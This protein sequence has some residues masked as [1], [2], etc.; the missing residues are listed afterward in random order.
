MTTVVTD[1]GRTRSGD[2]QMTP[3]AAPTQSRLLHNKTAVIYG[4]SSR[5]SE[6]LPRSPTTTRGTAQAHMIGDPSRRPRTGLVGGPAPRPASFHHRRQLLHPDRF[7]EMGV[8]AGVDRT[9]PVLG[10]PI[11][12]H[13]D[14][15]HRP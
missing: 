15:Q 12:A 3:T 11:P 1:R 10:L 6:R 13:C 8:E 5:G 2:E 7:G 9:L 14:E 4:A